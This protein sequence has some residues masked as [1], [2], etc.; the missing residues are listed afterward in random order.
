MFEYSISQ[1]QSFR[2][3]KKMLERFFRRSRDRKLRTERH[4]GKFDAL[5]PSAGGIGRQ[6]SGRTSTARLTSMGDGK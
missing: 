2:G 5:P 6:D 1:F 4:S 3:L